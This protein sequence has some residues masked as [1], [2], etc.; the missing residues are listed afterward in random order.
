[1]DTK[2]GTISTH[3]GTLPVRTRP[4]IGV[5]TAV[6][7]VVAAAALTMSVMALT[8]AARDRA[9]IGAAGGGNRTVATTQARLWD[10]DKIEAMAGRMLA[11][12]VPTEDAAVLW[13]PGRLEAMEGRVLAG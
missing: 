9:S 2:T 5:W 3:P 10:V 12:R 6:V 11:E 8:I 7:T 1:M 13:D 4:G